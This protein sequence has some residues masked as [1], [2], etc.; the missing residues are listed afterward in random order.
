MN[1]FGGRLREERE[2]LGFSQEQLGAIG[3]VKKLAQL[4]YEKGE[5][6]PDVGYLSAVEKV[7]VDYVFVISGKRRDL[8]STIP[9]DEQLLLDVYRSLSLVKRREIL[10]ALLQGDTSSSAKIVN[11]GKISGT[12]INA[13]GGKFVVNGDYYEKD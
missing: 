1:D 11:N 5:R 4:K 7:G 3:G 12:Q 6:K 2:R 13:D 9:T 10:A 8:P